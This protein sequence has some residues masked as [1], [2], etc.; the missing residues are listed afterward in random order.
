[1]FLKHWETIN[2][3]SDQ[4]NDNFSAKEHI[5]TI[6]ANHG[7]WKYTTYQKP[8]GSGEIIWYY[9]T[10]LTVYFKINTSYSKNWREKMIREIKPTCMTKRKAQNKSLCPG[11][12]L[13]ECIPG[14]S[15]LAYFYWLV[16]FWRASVDA[17]VVWTVAQSCLVSCFSFCLSLI[18]LL[19]QANA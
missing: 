3:N 10:Q 12:F 19:K 17:S 15:P 7:I 1:M 11:N 18:V 16:S 6:F 9:H 2:F 4:S 5:S 8:R 14:N 13:N